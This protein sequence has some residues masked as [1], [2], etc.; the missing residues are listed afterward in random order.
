MVEADGIKTETPTGAARPFTGEPPAAPIRKDKDVY[1]Q[2]SRLYDEI[3]KKIVGYDEIIEC[4]LI[5]FLCDGHV[6][7]ESVPGMGKTML[8]KAISD[9]MDMDFKR[10]QGTADLTS[11]DISGRITYDEEAKRNVFI[12]GPVFTNILLMDEI[13]RAPPMSQS[14]LLEIM[15]EKRVTVA[16]VTYE[17]PKPFIVLATEN[18]LEQKGVFPLPEAQKD[19]FLFKVMMMYLPKEQETAIVKTKFKEE[20]VA[21]ILTPA[22]ILIMRKEA[23]ESAYMSDSMIEYAV[24]IVDETRHRKELQVGASPRASINFMK[25]SKARVFLEGRENVTAADI[26]KLAYPI[27]RHRIILNPE[28]VEMRVT[29]DDIIRKILEKIDA[30]IM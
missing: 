2:I 11:S 18:P 15:E 27:L 19:R 6:L 13:N 28:Y 30:P 14:A 8:T 21:R 7:L 9:A 4:V 12:K 3:R 24:R 26:K 10:I 16:G 1:Q 5:G 29:P 23:F 17:L 25:A 22:E 20:K